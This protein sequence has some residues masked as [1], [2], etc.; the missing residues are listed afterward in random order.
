M[1]SFTRKVLPLR[2]ENTSPSNKN[3]HVPH[4]GSAHLEI[5]KFSSGVEVK[6]ARVS[7]FF[8]FCGCRLLC[9]KSSGLII[10]CNDDD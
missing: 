5:L 8:K 3:S 6:R 10:R 7:N 9:R 4:L 2:K 1:F